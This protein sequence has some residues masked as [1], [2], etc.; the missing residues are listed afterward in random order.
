MSILRSVCS[1]VG[2]MAVGFFVFKIASGVIH[3]VLVVAVI[4]LILHFV[5]SAFVMN[6]LGFRNPLQ[7]GSVMDGQD[8]VLELDQLSL[9]EF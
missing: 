5:S 6:C 4:L 8:R 7:R 3:I 1:T 2:S 9:S